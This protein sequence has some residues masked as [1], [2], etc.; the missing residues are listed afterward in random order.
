MSKNDSGGYEKFLPF[1]DVNDGLAR[2][3]GNKKLYAKLLK[4]YLEM[5]DINGIAQAL[6]ARDFQAAREQAH[7]L[8][9]V[10]GNLSLTKNFECFR[11]LDIAVKEGSDTG[12]LFANLSASAETTASLLRELI[13]KLEEL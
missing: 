12:A 4:S 11:A 2:L 5:A 3:Q 9:G 6:S 13:Q 10:S 8:K 1:I 7:S